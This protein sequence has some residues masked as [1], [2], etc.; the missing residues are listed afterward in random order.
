[1][2]APTPENPISVGWRPS[3]LY[4]D[5]QKQ[6]TAQRLPRLATYRSTG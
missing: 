6:R 5:V 4:A 1:M 2:S 3:C